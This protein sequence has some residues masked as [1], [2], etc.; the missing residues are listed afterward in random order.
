M[1]CHSKAK[2]P[3]SFK[4]ATCLPDFGHIEGGE[5]I[6]CFLWYVRVLP[7]KASNIES[8][9][10]HFKGFCNRQDTLA[11]IHRGIHSP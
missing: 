11:E 9:R 10:F 7:Q 1:N 2:F 5:H 4:I 8:R 6:G 3:G